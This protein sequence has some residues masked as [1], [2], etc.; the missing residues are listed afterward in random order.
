MDY[1]LVVNGTGNAF[2]QEFGCP[3]PR[4]AL[5]EPVANMSVSIVRREGGASPGMPLSTWGSAS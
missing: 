3:C 2:L 1:T 5:R 4:C